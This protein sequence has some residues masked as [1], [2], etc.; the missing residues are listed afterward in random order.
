RERQGAGIRA[1]WR[2]RR[3]VGLEA[4]GVLPRL[5][6]DAAQDHRRGPPFLELMRGGGA[7]VQRDPDGAR[8]LCLQLERE[9]DSLRSVSGVEVLQNT[10]PPAPAPPVPCAALPAIEAPTEG[11]EHIE[12]Q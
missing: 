3:R 4:Q 1:A 12:R 9:V 8:G 11:G 5:E 7:A 10:L 6:H 2:L